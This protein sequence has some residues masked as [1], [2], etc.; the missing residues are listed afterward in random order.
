MGTEM[1]RDSATELKTLPVQSCIRVFLQGNFYSNLFLFD[2]S[3]KTITQPWMIMSMPKSVNVIS[4]S[5]R[6]FDLSGSFFLFA[7]HDDHPQYLYPDVLSL[8]LK[9]GTVVGFAQF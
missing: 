5:S 7:F 3:S 9:G 1:T 4:K 8:E 6:R 2:F